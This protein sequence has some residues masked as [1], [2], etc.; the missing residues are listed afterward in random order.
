MSSSPTISAPT[1][2]LAVM[3]PPVIKDTLGGREVTCREYGFI[4][5]LELRSI[6]QPFIDDL[7]DVMSRTE[8]SQRDIDLLVAKH[9]G[10]VQQMVAKSADVDLVFIE[11][12]SPKDGRQLLAMW[13][14]AN[15]PFFITCATDYLLSD[16]V[17]QKVRTAAADGL[18]SG[19]PSSPQ[20]TTQTESVATP[21]VS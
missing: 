11:S 19:Q 5:E 18:M 16:L 4:E 1:D 10:A 21:T 15:G 17:A 13:W 2:D 8:V 14:S 9:L 12:L 7:M 20:D 3:H 6:S